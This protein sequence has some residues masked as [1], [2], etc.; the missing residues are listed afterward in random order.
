MAAS[1]SH[2]DRCARH[3]RLGAANPALRC[4]IYTRKS[5]EAELEQEFNSLDAQRDAC[6]AFIQSQAS[7]GWCCLSSRYDDGG[8]S[9]ATMKRPALKRLLSDVEAG[10]ID[11][12]VVYKVDRLT[13]SLSDFAKIVEVFDERGA[14]FVSVTQQ[15]NTTS[16]MGRL[17]LNMLLSFAQFEREVTS[18]RIRDKIAASR[19]RGM[20]TG[21]PPPL[22]YDLKDKKLFVNEGE[23]AVVRHIFERY[24]ALGSVLAL[25]TELDQR[26]ILSKRRIE[27]SGRSV[28]GKPLSRGVLYRLLS[29]RL[30]RGE[31]GYKGNLYPGQHQAI[32]DEPLWSL[33]Q[34]ILLANTVIRTH[35]TKAKQLSLLAG[36]IF[37]EDDGR[38]VPSHATKKGKR[39]RYYVSQNLISAKREG[40]DQGYRIPAG[41]LEEIV[42]AQLVQFLSDQSRSFNTFEA[43]GVALS[44]CAVLVEQA[45]RLA[46][47]WSTMTLTLRRGVLIAF[48]NRVVIGHESLQVSVDVLRLIAFLTRRGDQSMPQEFPDLRRVEC[49]LTARTCLKRVGKETKFLIDGSNENFRNCSDRSLHRLLAQAYHFQSLMMRHNGRTIAELAA[50]AGVSSSYFSRVVRFSFLAPEIVSDVLRD[51]HPLELSAKRLS[52]VSRLPARWQDQYSLFGIG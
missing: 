18:E 26:G 46:S 38:I 22:G 49:T 48:M 33:A 50:E 27:K 1:N 47:R 35:G 21:G 9:G 15:F 12:I 44:D 30:Y 41:D 42:E 17:T 3:S 31:I 10:R 19:K 4:A 13:R 24:V 25:K 34:K 36:I 7:E 5:T 20:W 29:N 39:Y 52:K 6:E 45:V 51:R 23:A 11:T 14:S 40:P 43:S 2:R 32:V 16:S 37:D 28:G 8:I